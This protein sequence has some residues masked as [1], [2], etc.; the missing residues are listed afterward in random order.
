[1][2]QSDILATLGATLH[3]LMPFRGLSVVAWKLPRPELAPSEPELL[4]LSPEKN[5]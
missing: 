1:M 5:I 2:D 3:W 4:L